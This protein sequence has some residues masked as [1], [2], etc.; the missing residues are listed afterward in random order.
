MSFLFFVLKNYFYGNMAATLMRIDWIEKLES[1][2][3]PQVEKLN[4]AASPYDDDS[5]HLWDI[6]NR[7]D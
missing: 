1:K 5:N 4:M 3:L 2:S 6:M 7:L